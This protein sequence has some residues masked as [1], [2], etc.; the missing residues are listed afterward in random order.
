MSLIDA[1]GFGTDGKH[2]TK[3]RRYEKIPVDD[4]GDRIVRRDR[5]MGTLRE[6]QA[7]VHTGGLSIDRWLHAR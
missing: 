1:F 6:R 2:E 3:Q 5:L 7:L 4:G